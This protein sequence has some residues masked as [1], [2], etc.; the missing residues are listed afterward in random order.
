MAGITGGLGEHYYYG[1]R[2]LPVLLVAFIGYLL[3]FHW[4]Q[5]WRYLGHYVVLAVGYVVGFGPLLAYFFT[6]PGLYFGRGQGVLTWNHIPTNWEDV[7]LMWNTLWTLMSSNLLAVG[8]AGGGD[9]LYTSPLLFPVE[10]ALLALGVALLVWRWRQPSAFLI[11]LS[12]FGV[13]FVGGTLVPS[14]AFFAHWTP[15][16]PAIY[17]AIALPVA[18]F[19]LT[20]SREL[21]ARVR[22]FVTPALGVGVILLGIVNTDF[23]FNR[24]YAV[25]PEFEVAAAQARYEASLGAGYLV[26]NVGETWQP[27]N[28]QIVGYLV[29]RL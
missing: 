10:A 29:I 4:R 16:F 25:R 17:V 14:A 21:P 19:Q 12:G 26:F 23:Y 24:Y 18:M 6:H 28:S 15:A 2:L 22:R 27:Y 11:L 1:T 13:L 5:A 8:T 20:S 7:Q 9:P 3:V